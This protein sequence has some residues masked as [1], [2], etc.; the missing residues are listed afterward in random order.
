MHRQ[1]FTPFLLTI[2]AFLLVG[3]LTAAADVAAPPPEVL[4][5]AQGFDVY[6]GFPTPTT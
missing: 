5:R 6:L 1:I 3:A 2:P 4:P